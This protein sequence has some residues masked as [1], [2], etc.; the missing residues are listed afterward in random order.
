MKKL[1]V[2]GTQL[3]ASLATRIAL[4][5]ESGRRL[6][7]LMEIDLLLVA[8]TSNLFEPHEPVKI[9]CKS[10]CQEQVSWAWRNH[11]ERVVFLLQ[12]K[13]AGLDYE[14][15]QWYPQICGI[16]IA[17]CPHPSGLNRWWNDPDNKK[18]A[19]TFWKEL[20]D[21]SKHGPV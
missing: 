17:F 7:R 16:E 8:H 14:Y 21:W 5:S 3:N 2:V 9:D 6:S 19:K 12:P 15:L 4:N 18:K 13:R 11:V 20:G 1:L 10:R